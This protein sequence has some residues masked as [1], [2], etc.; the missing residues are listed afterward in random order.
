MTI[1]QNVFIPSQEKGTI[2]R[3]YSISD[4]LPV[5]IVIFVSDSTFSPAQHF[6]GS[7]QPVTTLITSLK[8]WR[9]VSN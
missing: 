8:Q 3:V 9:K 2:D 5:G 4:V 6:G 1:A 7:W